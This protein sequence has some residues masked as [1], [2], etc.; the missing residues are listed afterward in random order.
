VSKSKFFEK[1]L[2]TKRIYDGRIVSVRE[3]EVELS[4]GKKSKREVVEHPGAVAL[5]AIT[6]KQELVLVK[7]FRKPVGKEV[8]EIPAGLANKGEKLADAAKR[9]LEEETGFVAGSIKEILSAYSTPGYS[10]ELIRYFLAT[11]LT[12]KEQKSDEDELIS[13]ELVKIDDAVKRT[14]EGKVTD[15]KTIVGIN[16]AEKVASGQWKKI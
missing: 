15:N 13:V 8:V 9:E 5:I 12:K 1:T 6:A 2:S 4:N 11:D 7:Q 10:S 14:R 16:I 3:D